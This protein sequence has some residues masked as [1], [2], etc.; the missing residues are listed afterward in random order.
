[1]PFI[2]AQNL[3]VSLSETLRCLLASAVSLTVRPLCV[4]DTHLDPLGQ[5]RVTVPELGTSRV[6]SRRKPLARHALH[7][8][9]VVRMFYPLPCA[10]A[11]APGVTSVSGLGSLRVRAMRSTT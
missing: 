5:S 10:G 2:C 8:L 7:P 3:R 6:E 1:M 11:E 9:I 4:L